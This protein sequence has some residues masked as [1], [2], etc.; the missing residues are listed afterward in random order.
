MLSNEFARTRRVGG[1]NMEFGIGLGMYIIELGM[2][3]YSVTWISV[4]QM[5]DYN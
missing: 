1:Q 4:I 5:C 2:Q 3:W